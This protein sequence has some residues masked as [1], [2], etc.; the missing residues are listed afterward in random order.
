MGI[1]FAISLVYMLAHIDY[2]APYIDIYPA[3]VLSNNMS[4]LQAIM[5]PTTSQKSA[6][7]VPS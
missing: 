5:N 7:F 4:A 1:Y 2:S 3:T 6:S